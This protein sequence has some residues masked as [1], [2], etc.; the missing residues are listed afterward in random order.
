MSVILFSSLLVSC[1]FFDSFLFLE[2]LGGALVLPL[3]VLDSVQTIH[4]SA[5]HFIPRNSIETEAGVD[6]A[7]AKRTHISA[8]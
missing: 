5:E 4:E 8:L 3:L 6:Y 1:E 2:S 7:M